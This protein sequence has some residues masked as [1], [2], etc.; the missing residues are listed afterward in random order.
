[1][2]RITNRNLKKIW[3]NVNK[4]HSVG[5]PENFTFYSMRSSAASIYLSQDGANIYTLA[6]LMGRGITGIET[7]VQSILSNE[8]EM[9]ER[10]KLLSPGT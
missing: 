3:R 4:S 2:V 7:Y 10:R 8:E 5:I 9:Y 1:M 6:H